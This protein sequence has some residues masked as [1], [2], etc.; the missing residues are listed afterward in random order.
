MYD[1]TRFD[2]ISDY[3]PILNGIITADLLMIFY[4]YYNNNSDNKGSLL[5]WYKEFG[6]SAFIA[7]FAIIFIGLI[8]TRYI[9]KI[10]KLKNNIITFI[11]V[12][13]FLQIF[14]DILF[15]VFFSA[16]PKNKNKMIDFFKIY[17]EK[18]GKSAI[19][20]DSILMVMAI[21]LASMFA[22]LTFNTNIIL[23]S[24]LVYL[25]PYAINNN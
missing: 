18:Y 25:L 10:Y 5:N 17:A 3:L 9:F 14:H 11:L 24:F 4:M 13:L 7:D 23:L 21:L 2:K 15:Y 16:I 22:G 6:L 1:I 20:G 19:I 8:L 12:A